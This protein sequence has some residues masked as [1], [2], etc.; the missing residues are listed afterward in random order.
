MC[1]NCC[2]HDR[3]EKIVK[4]AKIVLEGNGGGSFVFEDDDDKYNEERELLRKR[5]DQTKWIAQG[6]DFAHLLE[7]ERSRIPHLSFSELK[8][9][10]PLITT[11]IREVT[12]A[13]NART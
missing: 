10:L 6:L 12:A 4:H 11:L 3:T 1:C 13:T 8:K 7:Y 9:L 5:L 2:Y